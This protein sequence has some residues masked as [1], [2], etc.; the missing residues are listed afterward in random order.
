MPYLSFDTILVARRQPDGHLAPDVKQRRLPAVRDRLGEHLAPLQDETPLVAVRLGQ[1][2][3]NMAK[4]S[5]TSVGNCA[6]SWSC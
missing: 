4:T 1:L 6:D 3:A 5:F 2:G